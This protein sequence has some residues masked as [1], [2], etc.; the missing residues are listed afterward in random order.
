MLPWPRWHSLEW[1]RGYWSDLRPRLLWL[2]VRGHGLHLRWGVPAWAIEEAL[3]ALALTLPWVLWSLQ[4]LPVGSR[5][6]RLLAGRLRLAFGGGGS[7][8]PAPWSQTL[9]LLTGEW[10]EVLRLPA[11]EPFIE[12][13]MP[14][15]ARDGRT[16]RVRVICL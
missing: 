10:E 5:R 11:G 3:R 6:Y 1:W 14:A 12:I 15:S 9:E 16:L 7:P 2:E 13:E 4:R 8:S